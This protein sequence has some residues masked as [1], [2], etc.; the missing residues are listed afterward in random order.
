MLFRMSV[1]SKYEFQCGVSVHK[2]GC[3]CSFIETQGVT[4][5]VVNNFIYMSF[6]G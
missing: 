3:V 2:R 4:K 5:F 1:V 6:G